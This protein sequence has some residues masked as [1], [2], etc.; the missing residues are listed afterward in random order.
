[1]LHNSKNKTGKTPK[2]VVYKIQCKNYE[3]TQMCK[4]HNS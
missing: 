3:A 2:N 1:M 4:Y